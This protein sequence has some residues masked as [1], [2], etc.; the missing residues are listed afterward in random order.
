VKIINAPF[1]P[2]WDDLNQQCQRALSRGFVLGI[3]RWIRLVLALAITGC[4]NRIPDF[5]DN[6][7]FIHRIEKES[8]GTLGTARDDVRDCLL[9]LFGTPDSPKWPELSNEPW[10]LDTDKVSRAAGAVGRA[11]DGVER[12]LWRKH[13]ATCHGITGDGAGPAAALQ[14]PYPRDFR[15]GSFKFKSTPIGSRPTRADLIKTIENGIPGTAMP[16]FEALTRSEFF[17]KDIEVLAEYVIYL[18]IRGEVERKLFTLAGLELD[19][20]ERI[21]DASIRPGNP[22]YDAQQKRI[23]SVVS[24]VIEPWSLAENKVPLFKV[25]P[26][27]D[28]RASIERGKD[29]FNSQTTACASCHGPEGKGDGKSQDFDEWTK[30]WTIRAGI[31]PLKREEWKPLKKLGALKPVKNPPRN[32]HL[33][34][35]RGGN[36]PED[37]YLR[38]VNGIEGTP[39]PAVAKQPENAQGLSEAQIW[40]VVN[41]VLSLSHDVSLNEEAK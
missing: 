18:S 22:R 9:E 1:L 2:S 31:D 27:D 15:R 34:A 14:A 36:H 23:Q 17:K 37:I 29:L 16:G 4:G 25:V 12:G 38:I 35:F 6:L 8:G 11:Q 24:E 5:K 41:F 21:F 40:D 19:D 10:R 39:M 32:L 13:C 7:L 26:A 3:T 30:D 33:G 20:S 28:L